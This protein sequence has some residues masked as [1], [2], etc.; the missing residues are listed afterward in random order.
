MTELWKYPRT[1]HL[2]G[3]RMQAGDEDLADYPFEDI[4]GAFAT[5]EEKVDG[6]NCGISFDAQGTLRLQ[7]RGHYLSGGPQERQ[8]DLFKAWAGCFAAQLYELL[9]TD[10]I[11]YGEWLYA[12]HTVY[13]DQ[14]PH[15]FMEF[16]IYD[17]VQGRFFSTEKRRALIKEAGADFICSV[18]VLWQGILAE[19]EDVTAHLGPSL[20]RSDRWEEALR[21][22]CLAHGMDWELAKKQTDGSCLM[23]GIYIK[24]EEGDYVTDRLKYVRSSFLSRILSSESHWKDRPI[25]P[26]QLC[27]QADLFGERGKER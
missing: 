3:S 13:Y 12:K 14:L 9:G 23:E 16:D 4:R 17:K 11:M 19:P 8:F 5:L 22:Y 1:R 25:V 20:F 27:G 7:S 2:Q 18:P 26:N 15:Y 24:I 10:L 21:T 6:A